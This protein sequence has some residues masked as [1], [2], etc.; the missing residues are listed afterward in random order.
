MP[1]LIWAADDQ[2]R[3]LQG[4][5][6]WRAY[7]GEGA[8]SGTVS[9]TA[10]LAPEAQSALSARLADQEPFE[11]ELSLRGAD[12]VPHGFRLNGERAAAGPG[13]A[14]AWVLTAMNIDDLLQERQRSAQLQSMIDASPN[15]IKVLD[16]EARLLSMN[17]GGQATLEI[18]DFD[19]CRNLLWLDFWDGPTRT[20]VQ[21]ALDRARQGE[22]VTF[23][24]ARATFK[25]TPKWWRITVAPLYDAEGRIHQL[26]AVSRDI[27]AT[28]AAQEALAA[29][30]AFVAFTEV[31]GA[32]TDVLLLAQH[33]VEVLRSTLGNVSVVYYTL[34]GELWKAQVWSADLAPETAAVLAAGVPV[35][36]PS[37]AQALQ[38]AQ[39]V[40]AAGWNAAA[41]G[42]D[43]TGEY[44]AG[45][46]FPCFVDGRPHGLLGLGTRQAEELTKR[47]QAVFR[48]VGRSLTLALERADAAQQL[49]DQRTEL[50]A[51]TRALEGFAALLQDLTVQSDRTVLLRRAMEL[52]R[53]LIPVGYASYYQQQGTRWFS[54][55]RVG[56]VGSTPLQTVINAG[57]PV[58]RTP[59]LD[60]PCETKEAWFQDSYDP[61]RDVDVTLVQHVRT[62]ATLPVVVDGRV[63]GIFSVVLFEARPWS[64]ADRTVLST[65]AHSLGLALDMSQGVMHLAE[66]RRK[67]E[68]ANEE[69]E[70]F[71]YS[72]S[73]DLRT[74]VR[75][76]MGFASLL[77]KHLGGG[78]DEKTA[79]YLSVI[80]D[81]AGR[82]NTLI[83]AMLDLS[84][85]SRQPLRVTPVDLG[86]L[87]ERVKLDLQPDL[88]GREVRWTVRS[89][90]MVMGDPDMLHQVVENLLS[91]ALKY[92]RDRDE[93]TIE[94][95]AE[96][97]PAE[98]AVFVRDNGAGFDP[99]YGNKLFTVFQRLHRQE[100]FEGVGV[101]LANVRRIIHRH[102]GDVAATGQPG[103][104]ATF[105][106]TL[107]R[108]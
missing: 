43:H 28:K 1:H 92:S 48:A 22:P 57:L 97:R 58:G 26:S 63:D 96:E 88:V 101:G 14:S 98:W 4:N 24:A 20:V 65:V 71:A 7:T 108:P 42:V 77:R 87:V 52:V 83:D 40:F 37:Y 59:S 2:G 15:C 5:A 18:D 66:E 6:A 51:R 103:Q 35:T 13:G 90:P 99:R 60:V 45:A 50:E 53:Q 85:T 11:L 75:H 19:V 49:I 70:A 17:E 44:G 102:G 21:D 80:A 12:G 94:I 107:P 81:G 82:M 91:N 9:V 105:S 54:M 72:V 95:W 34:Q 25:G 74:P 64:A 46:L 39:P 30:D 55:V 106:F 23:E 67:L 100:E 41:Q 69:L 73:H 62:V 104:G 38:T 16:L 61:A 31:A 10:L 33:A 78:L 29:L 68:A 8:L 84:R 79:R 3:T 89:L 93:V 32:G 86:R 76:I 56:A 36:A 47:E 27:T